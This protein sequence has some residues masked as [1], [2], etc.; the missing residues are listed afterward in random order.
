[1]SEQDITFHGVIGDMNPI[2]HDG[3]VVY[4]R[5]H[6]VEVLYFQGY[7]HLGVQRVSVYEFM[8]EDDVAKELNWVDWKAVAECVGLKEEELRAYTDAP[9]PIARAQV[10]E[11]VAAN[12]GFSELDHR[13]EEMT[14]EQAEEK[15]GDFV[16]RAHAAK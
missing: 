9:N 3:G 16:D 4:D 1:M 5:G 6:G 11:S 10:Y 13:P 12:Y 2:E 15:Y 8:V 7:T 14:L